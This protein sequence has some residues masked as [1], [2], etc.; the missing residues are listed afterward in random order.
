VES[1]AS[2]G[3]VGEGFDQ[4]VQRLRN[5]LARQGFS[6][7]VI[8][9]EPSDVVLTGDKRIFLYHSGGESAAIAARST[10]EQGVQEGNGVVLKGLF[11]KKNATYSFVWFPR[12]R[13]EAEYEMV[14]P[15]VKLQVNLSETFK[16]VI[17]RS[18]ERWQTLSQRHGSIQFMKTDLF[19]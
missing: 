5:L 17:I 14:P 10:F 15:G 3:A 6:P 18:R 4:A 13:A 16:V 8:W 12:D 19:R 1:S 2:E 7:N 11:P 9:I